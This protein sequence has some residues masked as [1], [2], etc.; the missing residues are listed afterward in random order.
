MKKE[1]PSCR[2]IMQA[3]L[4]SGDKLDRPLIVKKI[5]RD[6]NGKILSEKWKA[7]KFVAHFNQTNVTVFIEEWD[8]WE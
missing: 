8:T 7:V 3:M 4:E 1:A 5:K 6:K 2:E